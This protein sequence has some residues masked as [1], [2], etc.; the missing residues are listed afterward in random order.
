MKRAIICD[1]DGTLALLGKRNPHNTQ[2]AIDDALNEP[3]ANIVEVYAHQ[4]KFSIE[5]I[6]ITGRNEQYRKVTEDWL[7]KHGITHY[8]ALYMRR[9]N[10]RRKDYA[11]KREIYDSHIKDKYKVIFVLED[12]DQVVHMWR[13][14]GLACF[15]VAY[16][17]F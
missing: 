14:A 1:L 7:K 4:T 10:D 11:V 17:D 8:G 16:G 9:Q 3:V 6:L 12:R 15:Q 5:L 13:K 2:Q